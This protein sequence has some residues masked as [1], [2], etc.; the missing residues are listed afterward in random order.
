MFALNVVLFLDALLKLS[1]TSYPQ[2]LFDYDC[3]TLYKNIVCI[4][5]IVLGNP[6]QISCIQSMF[7]YRDNKRL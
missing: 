2:K 3:V 7:A 5:L 1:K 4:Y 6:T